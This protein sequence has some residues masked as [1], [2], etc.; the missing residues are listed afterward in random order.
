MCSQEVLRLALPADDIAVRSSW[1]RAVGSVRAA[2]RT[3]IPGSTTNFVNEEPLQKAGRFAPDAGAEPV[4][5][6]NP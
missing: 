4:G 1:R 3:A 6:V 5:S 2:I